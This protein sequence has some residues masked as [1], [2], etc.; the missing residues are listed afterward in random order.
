MSNEKDM[1]SATA[2]VGN[3]KVRLD[4]SKCKQSLESCSEKEIPCR[5]VNFSEG[6]DIAVEFG[7]NSKCHV[8]NGCAGTLKSV[9]S[10]RRDEE[11]SNLEPV[12]EECYEA[13]FSEEIVFLGFANA[14]CD[15]SAKGGIERKCLSIQANDAEAVTSKRSNEMALEKSNRHQII[16]ECGESLFSKE[17]PFLGV[18]SSAGCDIAGKGRADR[19]RQNIQENSAGTETSKGTKEEA[20]EKRNIQQVIDKCSESL[21]SEE[22]PCL[23]VTNANVGCDIEV[24]VEIAQN[25]SA[26]TRKS[27]GSEE[28]AVENIKLQHVIDECS[29]SLFREEIQFLDVVGSNGGFDNVVPGSVESIQANGA[30]APKSKWSKGEALEQQNLQIVID[31]SSESERPFSEEIPF[32]GVAGPKEGCDVAVEMKEK[33]VGKERKCQNIQKDSIVT[34]M[35]EGSNKNPG[36]KPNTT[37]ITDEC[38]KKIQFLCANTGKPDTGYEANFK[39]PEI[40]S[41]GLSC[42]KSSVK[43]DLRNKT[44]P[45]TLNAETFCMWDLLA[46]CSG[47][48]VMSDDEDGVVK[49]QKNDFSKCH[50]LQDFNPPESENLDE[51]L[52]KCEETCESESTDILAKHNSNRFSVWGVEI[53][54]QSN[55]SSR[56]SEKPDSREGDNEQSEIGSS[57]FEDSKLLQE[58]FAL[59]NNLAGETG[60][61]DAVKLVSSDHALGCAED[62]APCTND[63]EFSQKVLEPENSC[64]TDSVFDSS[65]DL[66]TQTQKSFSGAGS[67]IFDENRSGKSDVGGGIPGVAHSPESVQADSGLGNSGA[68]QQNKC[69]MVHIPREQDRD[70][71]FDLQEKEDLDQFE[72]NIV[73]TLTNISLA[74]A[75][76]RYS[77]SENLMVQ[78]VGESQEL[79]S[80]DLFASPNHNV[81]Y[82]SASS[83]LSNAEPRIAVRKS[84]GIVFKTPLSDRSFRKSNS[85]LN[86]T[87]T[88]LSMRNACIDPNI[89]HKHQ[90]K[91][92]AVGSRIVNTSKY[93]SACNFVGENRIPSLHSVENSLLKRPTSCLKDHRSLSCVSPL[94]ES[95]KVPKMSRRGNM[96]IVQDLGS[97]CM[98][99]RVRFAEDI[100][101]ENKENISCISD[102]ILL[103]AGDSHDEVWK[104]CHPAEIRSADTHLENNS[105]RNDVPTPNSTTQFNYQDYSPDLFSSMDC[106]IFEADERHKNDFSR[107]PSCGELSESVHSRRRASTHGDEGLPVLSFDASADL[108]SD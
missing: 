7:S 23:G 27:E 91:C 104:D 76:K 106:S 28:K 89:S 30:G 40:P 33:K 25:V 95:C 107:F 46:D 75:R 67:D 82:P 37:V 51:F 38:S 97:P 65:Y 68:S 80:Q 21:F 43:I 31:E 62:L 94:S 9:G 88:P 44:K 4:A 5:G 108:F 22:I 1:G 49:I 34:E 11:K 42:A 93:K 15:V 29:E 18:E 61:K 13:L 69:D 72:E 87:S 24:G 103:A 16:D 41:A 86:R 63:S 52:G 50:K 32:L 100:S 35:F 85:I 45:K 57:Y 96:N 73:K 53:N 2:D 60:P 55:M 99:K 105:F 92:A 47:Y 81:I 14:G 3:G 83:E 54:C 56:E 8:Q 71:E 39:K 58:V 10:N 66:F 84:P 6:C 77:E 12:S 59:E 17:I 79:W 19:K 102:S 64:D 36:E 98:K 90:M 101:C 20:L 74:C 48:E 78:F 70:L 26:T